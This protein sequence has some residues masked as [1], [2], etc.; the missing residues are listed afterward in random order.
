VENTQI[1]GST[2]NKIRRWFETGRFCHKVAPVWHHR[3][4]KVFLRASRICRQ[5]RFE[6]YEAYRL[7]LFR[8]DFDKSRLD[9]FISRKTLTKIQ[10][11]FNPPGLAELARNKGLFHYHCLKCGI[12]VPRLF[13][14]CQHPLQ[15]WRCHSTGTLSG[16]EEK[17][18]FLC[19]GLPQTFVIKPIYGSYGKG[20][21]IFCRQDSRFVD[22]LGKY[23]SPAEL[24]TFIE[25]KYPDGFIIQQKVENHPNIVALTGCEALQ[26]ARIISFV[27]GDGT[28]RLI[29]SHFKPITRP[30]IVIDTYI[31]GLTGNVEVPVNIDSGILGQGNQIGSSGPGIIKVAKHPI[32]GQSFAGFELPFWRDAC[33]TV[34]YAAV[35]FL[36]LRTIG[37]DVA[38]GCDKTYII[39]ANVWW[40]PP[41]QHGRMN[42]ILKQMQDQLSEDNESEQRKN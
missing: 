30:G 35:S 11:R 38:L 9:D 28:V 24:L 1:F 5:G 4:L 40:D 23:Y 17:K 13:L 33:E 31:E 37:W 16:F 42:E 12:P 10:E 36:P 25:S 8:P 20:V 41:N 27:A 6:P 34:K 32:T 15:Q 2:A 19:T 7:G 21:V 18:V 26:T 39:E 3:Y 22:H 14:V 29:H